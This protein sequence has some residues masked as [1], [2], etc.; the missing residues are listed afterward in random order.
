[1][2]LARTLPNFG[3]ASDPDLLR[4]ERDVRRTR[5]EF[6]PDIRYRTHLRAQCSLRGVGLLDQPWYADREEGHTEVQRKMLRRMW[7]SAA[8]FD[9]VL[10]FVRQERHRRLEEAAGTEALNDPWRFSDN[11]VRRRR[12]EDDLDL[13]LLGKHPSINVNGVLKDRLSGSRG[14]PRSVGADAGEGSPPRATSPGDFPRGR[15]RTRASGSRDRDRDRACPRVADSQSVPQGRET[16]R[17]G[18]IVLLTL[19]RAAES[20]LSSR[21]CP[22]VV[23]AASPSR[24]CP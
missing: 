9:E 3:S 14:S 21:A 5:L 17:F 7:W 20:Q 15:W 1:M 19:A 2:Q 6:D 4:L 13:W 8:K 11:D 18:D 10:Q 12:L 16:D 22:R 24:A 23:R